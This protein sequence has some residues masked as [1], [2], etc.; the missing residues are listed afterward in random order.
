MAV[1]ARQR[2]PRL[3]N[4]ARRFARE[5]S[6]FGS[7]IAFFIIA[8]GLIPLAIRRYKVE[9][10]RV[11]AQMSLGVGALA[12]IGGSV[13]VV[14]FLSLVLGTLVAGVAHP[15]LGLVGIDVLGGFFSAN[16]MTRTSAPFLVNFALSVTIGAGAT[17]QL[18]AMRISEEIDALEVMAVRSIGYLVSTPL[19][20]SV[21][22]A[23]AF[24]SLAVIS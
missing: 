19:V 20:S 3:Y 22:V 5:W 12:A 9:M 10:L 2:L 15:A 16:V 4:A 23:L 11:I 1:P 13:M 17:A 8:V 6:R 14:A 24:F 7:Q 21:V 18:G